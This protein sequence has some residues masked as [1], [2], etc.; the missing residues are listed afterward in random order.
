LELGEN[1]NVNCRTNIQLKNDSLEPMFNLKNFKMKSLKLYLISVALLPSFCLLQAQT[2][3]EIISKSILASGGKDSLDKIN[4]IIIESNTQ[5]M[6]NDLPTTT[7]IV[8]GKA[9]KNESDMNGQKIIQCYTEKGGWSVNPM[10]GGGPEPM[11]AKQYNAGKLSFDIGGP[12]INY[13]AKGNKVELL[14]KE[15]V[16]TVEAFKLKVVTKDSAEMTYFID[17]ATFYVIQTM[18]KVDMMGQDVIMKTSLSDYRKTQYG[19]M[20]PYVMDMNFGD[21]FQLNIVVKKVE[22]NKPIDPSIFEMPK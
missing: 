12:L 2:A 11:P 17:P 16:G 18:Q 20:M 6:G 19:Y 14:G 21:Q 7:T 5:V 8:N 10:S 22:F 15:T 9:Y 4:T 13:Q 3:E 1:F